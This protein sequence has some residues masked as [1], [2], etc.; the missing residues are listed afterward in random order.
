MSKK[1]RIK[2]LAKEQFKLQDK[3][4]KLQ[5]VLMICDSD[6]PTEQLVL[7]VDQLE[8]M[9]TYNDCLKQRINLLK[10]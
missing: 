7:M 3:I 1:E 8:A 9:K 6:I 4:A 5:S 10:E 2:K